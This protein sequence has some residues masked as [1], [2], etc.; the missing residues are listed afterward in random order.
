VSTNLVGFSIS[1]HGHRVALFQEVFFFFSGEG[2]SFW[3]GSGSEQ[4][5]SSS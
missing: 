3:F 5:P 1:N 4:N 2:P